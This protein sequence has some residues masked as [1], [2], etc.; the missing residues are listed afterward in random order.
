MSAYMIFIRDKM[1]DADQYAQ[2]L[3]T[4]APTLAAYGG[5]ILVLNGANQALEGTPI[6]GAVVLRFPDMASARAWYDSPDV[7]P[8]PKDAPS[9]WKVC[10]HSPRIRKPPEA[11]QCFRRFLLFTAK[12][13]NQYSLC[14]RHQT[15]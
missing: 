8:R 12:T 15:W 3:Q 5:E 6:D 10:K 4:A 7:L 9:W 13:G 1:L 2:Y 14:C 11:V